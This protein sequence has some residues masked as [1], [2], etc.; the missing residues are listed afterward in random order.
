MLM[1]G[2][3][4]RSRRTT[5]F[6]RGPLSNSI[7]IDV[8]S[9]RGSVRIF[10]DDSERDVT[11]KAKLRAMGEVIQL[12]HNM[13]H[14]K[15]L[16][17][18]VA[19]VDVMTEMLEDESGQSVLYITTV[20]NH[21]YPEDQWVELRI[22]APRVTNVRVQ[23]C[24]GLVDLQGV[25]GKINVYNERGDV[26]VRSSQPITE[27][28]EIITTDGDVQYRVEAVST[29]L[30]DLE[31]IAGSSDISAREGRLVIHQMGVSRLTA[32][33][34]EGINPIVIRTVNGNIKVAV[35]SDPEKVG[36]IDTFR[37]SIHP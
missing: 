14:K 23:T 35:R 18:Q 20:S 22:Y 33:L 37:P 4:A 13:F 17:A 1:T 15:K 6:D 36:L 34:G 29:G 9:F 31:A 19:D 26:L 5:I 25:S 16:R 8:E 11:V 27:P 32:E 10:A 3:G 2:C 24:D 28:V 30:F 7:A 12:K 21:P